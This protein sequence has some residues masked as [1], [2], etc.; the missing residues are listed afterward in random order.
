M[1]VYKLLLAYYAKQHSITE[2]AAAD[3][4]FEPSEDGET[5]RTPKKDALQSIL[6]SDQERIAKIKTA[7]ADTTEAYNK[8]YAD[9]KKDI[10]P[11]IESKLAKKYGIEGDDFKLETLVEDIVAKQTEGLKGDPNTLDE[12]TVKKH[13]AYLALER[14]RNE[15][16]ENLTAEHKAAMEAKDAGYA[17][18]ELL[19]TV[20][21][22][23]TPI[24]DGLKP[25]LT[26]TAAKAAVQRENFLNGLKSKYDFQKQEDGSI[27]ITDL[28]GNR[29]ED[30]HGNTM[31]LKALVARD[32]ATQFDFAVQDP[33]GGTGNEGGT[34]ITVPK[35]KE[36]YE[37]AILNSTTTEERQ[38]IAAAYDASSE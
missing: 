4:L 14:T 15:E 25:I 29:I 11:K 34:G 27:L 30:G 37:L 10:L 38:A 33:K 36:D 8:A 35:S 20:V 17:K 28:N 22:L 9:A 1:D 16:I 24:F 26:G 7:A 13:P 21:N 5:A 3:L 19:G 18:T 23:A 6:A 12:K 32:A 31:S 2:E